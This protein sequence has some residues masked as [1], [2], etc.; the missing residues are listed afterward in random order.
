[1]ARRSDRRGAYFSQAR[2]QWLRIHRIR[3][4][5]KGLGADCR[6]EFLLYLLPVGAGRAKGC[7]YGRQLMEYCLADARARGKAGVCMLGAQKQKNWLSDQRFA[8]KYGF[9]TVDTTHDGYELLALSFDG[10]APRFAPSVR[11]ETAERGLV[12][13]YDY[14]CPYIPQRVG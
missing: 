10:T 8:K 2:H 3:T 6:R 4:A 14:Q 9:C 5:R 12:I 1:M 7:G 11:Q 13:Y